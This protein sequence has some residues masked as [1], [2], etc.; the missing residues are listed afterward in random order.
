MQLTV[1]HCAYCQ[2]QF[3]PKSSRHIYCSDECNV[4]AQV[5]QRREKRR[6]QLTKRPCLHCKKEYRPMRSDQ[7]YCSRRCA[8]LAHYYAHRPE[9]IKKAMARIRFRLDNDPAFRKKWRKQSDKR[10]KNAEQRA[11]VTL[12]NLLGNKCEICGID[13]PDVL[14][15][16]HVNGGQHSQN[17]RRHNRYQFYLKQ[18]KAGIPLRLLCANHHIL[19]HRG[20]VDADLRQILFNKTVETKQIE[21]QVTTH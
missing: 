20:K 10:R 3:I 14:M 8:G 17:T 12:F 7:K 6:N 5:K 11:R 2:K 21:L 4:Q 1:K 16:H 15:I 9:L 13:I 18:Y 19:V